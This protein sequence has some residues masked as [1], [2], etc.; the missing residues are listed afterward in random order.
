MLLGLIRFARGTVE[1]EVKDGYLERFISLC[2]KSG[3]PLWNVRREGG[4][5]T[6]KTS[7]SGGK[8]LREMAAKS[9]VTLRLV[10]RAGVPPLLQRYHLRTGVFAGAALLLALPFVLSMFLWRVEISGCTTIPAVELRETLSQ[11]GVRT[12]ARRGAIDARDVERRMMLA[13]DRLSW[14]AVNLRGSTAHVEVRER[15]MAPPRVS[16][17]VPHNIVAS[18]GGYITE[19]IV[20]EGQP[21]V[22]TG[23]SVLAGDILVSGIMEDGK[24]KNRTVHARARI[25]AQVP[26]SLSV[27][28][29]YTRTEL[30]NT[31]VTAQRRELQLFSLSLPLSTAGEPTRPWTAEMR[32][33][34]IPLIS[35]LLPITITRYSYTL[36]RGVTRQLTPEEA[37][38]EA[39]TQL[40]KEELQAFA[41]GSIVTREATGQELPEGFLLFADYLVT[42]DIAEEREIFKNTE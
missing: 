15:D 42:V 7:G 36:Q 3:V 4:T 26:G 41:P 9:G 25:E 17:V 20:Y 24:Q 39:M 35:R 37:R 40:E 8:R 10:R 21:M 6:A 16:D 32:E 33:E 14:I 11:L 30:V 12:G 34:P 23:D 13:E 28:V 22:K 38:L 29:P 31:G 18:Q 5:L 27:M 19:M 2:G 1:F